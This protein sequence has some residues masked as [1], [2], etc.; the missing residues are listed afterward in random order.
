[1]SDRPP[2]SPLTLVRVLAT[3]AVGMQPEKH[4]QWSVRELGSFSFPHSL[5]SLGTLGTLAVVD[6]PSWDGAGRSIA[7]KCR[8]AQALLSPVTENTAELSREQT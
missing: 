8:Q 1:M 6:R 3:T 5:S 7:A 4:G 2:S